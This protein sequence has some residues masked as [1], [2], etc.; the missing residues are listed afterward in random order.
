MDEQY[1]IVIR[2]SGEMLSF[3]DSYSTENPLPK[4]QA[5]RQAIALRLTESPNNTVQIMDILTGKL[6]NV[7]IV[8]SNPQVILV[9]HDASNG[10]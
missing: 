8:S 9:S 3:G 4:Q 5:I 6:M 1:V 7:E 10:C 2:P